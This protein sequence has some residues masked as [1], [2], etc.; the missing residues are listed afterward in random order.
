MN[1]PF[2][3]NQLIEMPFSKQQFFYAADNF[4]WF[5]FHIQAA[6]GRISNSKYKKKNNFLG[7][8]T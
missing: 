1:V 7:C 8:V 2:A 6:I 3:L 4:N 5:F